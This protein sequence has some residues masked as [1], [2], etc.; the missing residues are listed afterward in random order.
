MTAV[1]VSYE[2][3]GTGSVVYFVHGIGSRKEGWNPLIEQLERSFTCVSFDLRGHG[4]SPVPQTPFALD[5][6]VAILVGVGRRALNTCRTGRSGRP[7]RT[8]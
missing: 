2:I 7:G 3:R 4:E 5:E 1:D 6:L 8:P